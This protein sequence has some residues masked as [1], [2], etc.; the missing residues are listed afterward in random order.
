MGIKNID[1]IEYSLSNGLQ[2]ILHEDHYNPIVSVSV[3]YH[4]GGKNESLGRSGFAHF[5]EHLMFEGS[6]NLNRGD[7]F[8]YISSS[9][10]INNAYTTP[11]E[12]FYYEVL[13]SNYLDLA[14]WLESERMLHA[15]VD[16]NGIDIQREV[17]KEEKRMYIDNVSYRV[18]ISE[19][20]PSLLFNKHPYRFPLIGLT[21]DIDLS[22]EKDFWDF[23]KTYYVPNNAILCVSGDIDIKKTKIIIEKYF[24]IIPIGKKKIIRP[25]IIEESINNEI[26]FTY[27]DKNCKVP[28]VI[29]SYRTPKKTDYNTYVLKIINSFLSKGESSIIYKNIINKKQLATHAGSFFQDLED[30]GIFI[31]YAI[32]RDGV[33][34]DQL[35]KGIDEEIELFKKHGIS[36]NNL[37]KQINII[38]KKNI[39]NNMSMLGVS[40]FLSECKLYY[41]DTN[42][43]NKIFNKYQSVSVNDVNNCVN[44]FLKTNKRVRLYNIPL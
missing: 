15:K 39:I 38:E 14:L 30:Y 4:V 28:A 43:V 13:P 17:V 10:G 16:K 8:K 6:V 27:K 23:Y 22:I 34:L 20:I 2:V 44:K 33:S 42:F 5:F 36:D 21:K 18:A 19:K 1:F 3:L 9:G 25:N 29:I 31:I 7:F 26:F 37:Q 40:T 11:D 35:T 24:S 41:N 12:T 32:L